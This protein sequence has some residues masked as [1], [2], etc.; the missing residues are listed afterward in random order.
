VE[1]TV[2]SA[3]GIG[4][5]ADVNAFGTATA[6]ANQQ[7]ASPNFTLGVLEAAPFAIKVEP[8]RL[9]IEQGEKT[10][11]RIL[12]ERKANYEDPIAVELLNLPGQVTATKGIIAKGQTSIELQVTS[13]LNAVTGA[14]TDVYALGAGGGSDKPQSTSSS[15]A[16]IVTP[17][18][19]FDLKADASEFK[20]TQGGKAKLK[21]AAERKNG[22][23]GPIAVELR[24]L[25]TNVTAPVVV[26]EKGKNT[27]EVEVS[28]AAAAAVGD[29]KTIFVL[30]IATGAANQPNVTPAFTLTVAKK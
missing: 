21:I 22:Y 13:A 5:K 28:A 10:T 17:G 29:V 4:A 18:F 19:L 30:G 3:A 15:L 9:K 6:A 20:L 25:P 14:K 11:V 2:A 8:A 23:D 12:A 16:L 26:I 7:N 27:A 1:V 24:N